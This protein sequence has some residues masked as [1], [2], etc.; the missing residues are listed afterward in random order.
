M[1]MSGTAQV[2]LLMANLMRSY[3]PDLPM[4]EGMKAQFLA[5]RNEFEGAQQGEVAAELKRSEGAEAGKQ[6]SHYY[7][8]VERLKYID[9]YRVLWLFDVDNPC[10]QHA[11]KKLLVAGARGGKDVETDL[12]E[13]IASINR[14]LEMLEED[15]GVY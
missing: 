3:N 11:I 5:I 13:A 7:K 4:S 10:I 6:F 2:A 15:N 14:A 9:V 8:N 1:A 12:R